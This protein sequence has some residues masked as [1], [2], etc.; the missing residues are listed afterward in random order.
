MDKALEVLDQLPELEKIIYLEPRG[1]RYRYTDPKL[2]S[3][4]DFI[5]LGGRNTAT[6]TRTR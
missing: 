4:D 5:A 1:I 2:M 3:W 6:P